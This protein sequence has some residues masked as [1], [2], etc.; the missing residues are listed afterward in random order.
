MFPMVLSFI[1]H[2]IEIEN[3]MLVSYDNSVV[4]IT[5]SFEMIAY[6]VVSCTRTASYIIFV[7]K[8]HI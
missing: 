2:E 3:V 1:V 7:N 8:S 6:S 4:K 5:Q